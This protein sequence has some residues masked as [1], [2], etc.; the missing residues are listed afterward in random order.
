MLKRLYANNTNI[1]G[2]NVNFAGGNFVKIAV[3]TDVCINEYA[4]KNLL[5]QRVSYHHK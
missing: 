2:T 1:N 5:I 3:F 4:G